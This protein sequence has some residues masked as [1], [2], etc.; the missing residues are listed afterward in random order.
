M[1][2]KVEKSDEDYKKEIDEVDNKRR[3][4]PEP[5]E[6]E[7]E[8]IRAW[9]MVENPFASVEDYSDLKLELRWLN[10]DHRKA[11]MR[12]FGYREI[13]ASRGRQEYYKTQ[14]RPI[15]RNKWE[16][17]KLKKS[18][19]IIPLE[20]DR[21]AE[22]DCTRIIDVGCGDGDTLQRIADHIADRWRE[23]GSDGHAIELVGVDLNE[24]RIENAG[25]LCQP[26]HEKITFDFQAVDAVT[27]KVP[28]EDKSF[29]Y[30]VNTGVFE[31]L[32]DEQAANMMGEICRVT[33]KGL[34]LEDLND[35]GPGGFRRDDFNP[36]L[37]P[38]GF[39]VE[40]R[41]WMFTEPFVLEGS[42]DPFSSTPIMRVQVFFA[43]A[44]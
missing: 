10:P 16:Y 35:E 8:A 31:I 11:H 7:F 34:Y 41:H 42:K 3:A 9:G 6:A 29:T 44:G 28:F 40:T 24:R 38:H 37:K 33:Q 17:L 23:A 25:K 4:I 26:P 2:E 20:W 19:Y 5:K 18:W 14:D 15:E 27:G 36:L 13:Y 21:F 32:D 1:N 22:A 30:A 39:K 43:T 12:R